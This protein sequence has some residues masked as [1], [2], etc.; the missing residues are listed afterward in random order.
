MS[1]QWMRE[2]LHDMAC[3]AAIHSLMYEYREFSR[4]AHVIGN[5]ETPLT[6]R[7][8]ANNVI[9]LSSYKKRRGQ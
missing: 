6:P 4:L 3:Y 2:V 1:H 5:S 9:D 8:H 7:N